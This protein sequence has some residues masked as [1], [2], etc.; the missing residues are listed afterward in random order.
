MH[1]NNSQTKP[2]HTKLASSISSY[3]SKLTLRIKG[4]DKIVTNARSRM[5]AE[6]MP[7]IISLQAVDKVD[8]PKIPPVLALSVRQGTQP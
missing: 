2:R 1:H 5:Y 6:A 4:D 3:N 8:N 7:S